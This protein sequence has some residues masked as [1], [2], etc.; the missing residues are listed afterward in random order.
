MSH[1]IF[2]HGKE[3]GKEIIVP[4]SGIKFGRSP[5]NDLVLDDASVMLF[6]GR[7]F[8]KSDGTLWVTDFS[9]AEKTTVGGEPVDEYM[10]KVGELVEVGETAFRVICAKLEEETA[11][12]EVKP[13]EEKIDLGFKPEPESRKNRAGKD[14]S[15]SST[16]MHR[17]L[18][19]VVVV[20]VVVVLV[21]AAPYILNKS[22]DATVASF[23][24]KTF[25]LV[26][27]CIRANPSNIFRYHLLLSEDGRATLEVDD[28]KSRHLTKKVEIPAAALHNLSRRLSTSGF[29]DV[30]GDRVMDAPDQYDLYDI[31][32]VYNG[33][34]NQVR[35]L[36]REP[37]SAV[38]DAVALIEEFVLKQMDIPYT[39]LEDPVVL[40][41]YAMEAF[42]IGESR[43]AERDVRQGNL[44]ESIKQFKASMNFLEVLE[45]KPEL[46]R[47]ARV[48]LEQAQAEQDARYKDYMFNVEGAIRLGDWREASKFL[49]I[50]AELIPDRKDDR[51]KIIS[52]KQLDVED[53][54][55]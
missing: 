22:D 19:V 18:Q 12:A 46:Y 21:V 25:S 29:F 37:P 45:P 47:Q 35:V 43:F 41:R 28:L 53:H 48:K 38:K 49:K 7:F 8:F 15:K 33:Q 39:L 30:Q 54:L 34:C 23:E 13:V 26:Y 40:R 27:E 52:S 51:Y 5:A 3:V 55:R 44:A 42:K 6:Q 14:G 31:A 36:N 24:N 2:E 10:L 1:L 20:L 32:I 11:V 4:P 16:L 50:L 9:A 17:V